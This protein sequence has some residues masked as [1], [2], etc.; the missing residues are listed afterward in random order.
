[1]GLENLIKAATI[2]TKRIPEVLFIIVGTG[3]LAGQLKSLV[4]EA[5]LDRQVSLVGY[6][7]DDL[8]PLYYRAAD[9]TVVPTV[10][11]EGFGLITLESLASGTPVLVTPIGGLPEAVMGLSDKMVLPD[12]SIGTLAEG[13]TA[14]LEKRTLLPSEVECRNYANTNFSWRSISE[15]VRAV[16]DEVV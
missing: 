14:V 3:P 10:A 15:R 8:L 12:L 13:I 1:M 5:S 6:V 2:V 4:V 16:Y 11:F 7:A 9:L